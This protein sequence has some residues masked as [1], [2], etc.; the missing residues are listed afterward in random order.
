[1]R[2]GVRGGGESVD[3]VPSAPSTLYAMNVFL[4]VCAC[5]CVC[6]DAEEAKTNSHASASLRGVREKRKRGKIMESTVL[7]RL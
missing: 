6:V 7:V 2:V 4:C 5:V 3:D 1:M